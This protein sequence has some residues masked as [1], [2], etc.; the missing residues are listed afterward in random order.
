ML[1]HGWHIHYTNRRY[2]HRL[3]PDTFEAY[4]KQRYRWASRRIPDFQEALAPAVA[5]LAAAHARAEA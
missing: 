3:L 1:E 2:G 4:K 5:A